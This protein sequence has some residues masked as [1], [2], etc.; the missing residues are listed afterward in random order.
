MGILMDTMKIGGGS[1]RPAFSAPVM[2]LMVASLLLSIQAAHAWPREGTLA[3]TAR[4]ADVAVEWEGYDAPKRKLVKWNELDGRFTTVRLGAGFLYEVASYSQDEASKAQFQLESA[5]KVRDSRLLLSGRLK[6]SRPIT[7]KAGIMYDG[8]T[9][10]WFLRET[11]A[12]VAVPELW[13]DV[14]VGRTKEG[15]SLNKVMNGYFGWTMERQMALD[16]IPI[17]ADG[18][19]WLG[20]IPSRKLLWNVGIFTDWLSEEESFSTYDWQVALRVAWVAVDDTVHNTVLH[21]GGNARYGDVDRGELRVRSRPETFP[22]PYFIDTGPFQASHS[23]HL[24]VEAYYRK[25]PFMVGT[26]YHLHDVSSA[27]AGNPLFFGGEVALTW[28]ITGESRPYATAGGVFRIPSPGK[29]LFD[30][31][32]GAVEA[33]LRL[34]H[35]NLDNGLRPGGRFWRITPMVN[36]YLSD[37]LRLEFAYGYGILD[38]FG[39]S[40]ATHFFQSRIQVLI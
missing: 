18:V 1:Q 37:N 11:G 21:I 4:P 35:L 23:R 25:G 12:M 32:I 13:G 20:Y 14:F 15:Y 27:E 29:P 36:W 30:G 17:L 3:D 24:G 9:D 6:T 19:R 34:S 33:V 40:G 38:R 10:S 8:P 22:A 16:I 28:V 31:G 2:L 26:E 7:W 39:L 5:G